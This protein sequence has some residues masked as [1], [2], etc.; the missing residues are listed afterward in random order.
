MT[1]FSIIL[2]S[3]LGDY[4]GAA[5]LRP[6]KLRRAIE[7]VIAQ[8]FDGWELIVVADGCDETMDIAGEY[9]DKRIKRV[10]IDKAPMWS[11]EPRNRGI[12]RAKGEFIIYLDNDD[13]YGEDHLQAIADQLA[14][15]DWVYYNDYIYRLSGWT[16][17]VCNIHTLGKNGTSNV[18]HKK[19]L[20]ARWKHTGYAHDYHFIQSL[21]LYHNYSRIDTPEYF[22][23]HLPNVYDL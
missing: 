18:C 20:P 22:V 21:L 9:K 11:G 10:K 2:P 23:M 5:I 19:S 7:S 16:E 6:Q 1:K 13:A 12:E 15:Y 17:R 3:Y 14:D 8:T 4:P